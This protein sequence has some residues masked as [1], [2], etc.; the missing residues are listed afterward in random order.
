[1]KFKSLLSLVAISGILFSY[2]AFAAVTIQVINCPAGG[3]GD[4]T[5]PPCNQNISKEKSLSY[6][7]DMDD[8]SIHPEGVKSQ[9]SVQFNNNTYLYLIDANGATVGS[10]QIIY[11]YSKQ[12][13]SVP[14]TNA[15]VYNFNCWSS[16]NSQTQSTIYVNYN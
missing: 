2:S 10:C 8:G 5:D 12:A 15:G 7:T 4:S 1:M 9:F 13:F 3:P 14:I 11:N 6:Q 16:Q